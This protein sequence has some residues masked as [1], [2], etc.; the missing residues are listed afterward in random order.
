MNRPSHTRERVMVGVRGHWLDKGDSQSAH[1][2]DIMRTAPSVADLL[3][4][5]VPSQQPPC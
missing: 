4:L 1:V 3:G 5:F 2:S